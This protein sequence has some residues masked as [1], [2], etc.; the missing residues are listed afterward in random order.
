MQICLLCHRCSS[1]DGVPTIFLKTKDQIDRRLTSIQRQLHRQGSYVRCDAVV[2]QACQEL[3]VAN[4]SDVGFGCDSTFDTLKIIC[5]LEG[6]LIA[7]IQ[8]YMAAR[9]VTH[10]LYVK[11]SPC[12]VYSRM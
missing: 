1:I 4:L 5:T 2:Q 10:L 8:T 11:L 9:Q 12:Y 7:L 6:L 3:G